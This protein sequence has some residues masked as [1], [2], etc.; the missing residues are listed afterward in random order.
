MNVGIAQPKA[1]L[2]PLGQR[3]KQ[4]REEMV[5]LLTVLRHHRT[6]YTARGCPGCELHGVGHPDRAPPALALVTPLE[7]REKEGRQKVG[8]QITGSNVH[9]T[10]FVNLPAEE[11]TAIRAFFAKDL[12]SI[13]QVRIVD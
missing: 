7:L 12:R 8:R 1:E 2:L 13:E 5:R 6:P 3:R 10:V 9:P 11:A 4:Q